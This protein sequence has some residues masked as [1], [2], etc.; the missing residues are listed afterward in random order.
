MQSEP[1]R[2]EDSG[3]KGDELLL[4]EIREDFG[5]FRDF[6]RENHPGVDEFKG[7]LIEWEPL[8]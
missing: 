8:A 4:R 5:Y 3:E 6:W 2:K 7:V 1:V